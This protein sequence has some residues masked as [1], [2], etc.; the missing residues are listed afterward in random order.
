M[1]ELVIDLLN[2]WF[3]VSDILTCIQCVICTVIVIVTM[4]WSD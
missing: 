1:K 3:T 4:S 2:F